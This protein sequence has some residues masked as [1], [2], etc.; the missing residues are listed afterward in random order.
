MNESDFTTMM[1]LMKKSDEKKKIG[2]EQAAGEIKAAQQAI[3]G[4][5]EELSKKREQKAAEKEAKEEAKKGESGKESQKKDAAEAEKEGKEKREPE[6]TERR[7]LEDELRQEHGEREEAFTKGMR[8]SS[9]VEYLRKQPVEELRQELEE[10]HQAA[11]VRGY[12]TREEE[13]QVEYV[14][15][16]LDQKQDDQ[17]AGLYT[18]SEEAARDAG[19]TQ[20]LGEH[21]R[22]MYRAGEKKRKEG[23]LYRT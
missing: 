1:P 18:F 10:L 17:D 5:Q 6:R 20:E 13:R 19:L 8:E 12:I 23:E 7:S 4:K 16:A 21:L 15:G 22:D 2:N 3:V 9:S 11:E 14:L